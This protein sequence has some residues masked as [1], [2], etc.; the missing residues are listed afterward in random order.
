MGDA[1]IGGDAL[2]DLQYWIWLSQTHISPKARFAVL[3]HFHTPKAAYFTEKD[4]FRNRTG[5]SGK[6]AELLEQRDLSGV[7]DILRKCEEQNL[8]ILCYGDP[9]YPECLRQIFAPPIV[10]YIQG[11]MPL[12]DKIPVIAVIGTR[13]ASPYGI[14]MGERIAYQISACG[15]TVVSMLNTGVDEAAARGALLS[16]RGCIGVLGTPHDQC[17]FPIARDIR[18][19][20]ALISEYPPGMECSRHFF[21]ERNRVAAG[22]SDGVVVIE[23]PEKSGTRL[24]VADAV[25][26]GRDIFALP[27]NVDAQNALGTLT[28][29]K[30]GAKLITCGSDVL[31]EYL[32]RYPGAIDLDAEQPVV[33]DP[34]QEVGGEVTPEKE[35]SLTEPQK[36]E[37]TNGEIRQ[38]LAQLT[39]DQLKII[40]AIDSSSTHVD[41]IAE[42]SGLSMPRV[43]AQ[44]T[45]LEIKGYVRREAGKRFALNIRREK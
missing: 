5:I 26:Q 45:V 22:I 41:D 13:K 37:K 42:R 38:Q 1:A 2:Q 33:P 16:G 20:G 25:E 28:L 32:S 17:R 7:Q 6:E 31:E 27:G 3:Q 29:L 11:N 24:F 19:H 18:N 34:M 39:E 9:T 4:S 40:A 36:T 43:L 44:L 23:A 12:L 30:E 21:R 14:K 8:H 35:N 10:L 15:G